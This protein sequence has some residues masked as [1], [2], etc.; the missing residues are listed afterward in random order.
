MPICADAP[1]EQCKKSDIR[2]SAIALCRAEVMGKEVIT[3]G[4]V[5]TQPESG[6]MTG[7]R[8]SESLYLLKNVFRR[9][10]ERLSHNWKNAGDSP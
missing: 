1:A 3:V 10:H 5:M 4:L 6:E 7:E 8:A 9:W 2:V